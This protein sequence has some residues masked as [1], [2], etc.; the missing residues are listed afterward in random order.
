M[1]F[2]HLASTPL[3]HL[4]QQSENKYTTTMKLKS[5]LFSLIAGL[6]LTAGT[7]AYAAAYIKFDG[8]DGESID[9]RYRNWSD[10]QSVSFSIVREV[11]AGGGGATSRAV[12]V[13]GEFTCVKELDK[14]SPLLMRGLVLGETIPTLTI[15]LTRST[16]AGD[17]PYLKYEL[18]DVLISSYSIA[19]GGGGS[20]QGEAPTETLSL[21]YEEIKVVYT[22]LDAGGQAVGTTEFNWNFKE[23]SGE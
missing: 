20:G 5:L 3:F 8:V 21:N 1:G 18:K 14:S 4:R 15:E 13:A 6:G 19:P 9:A 12:A 16:E 10:L 22:Q 23:N 17:Q 11:V 2:Q 7:D